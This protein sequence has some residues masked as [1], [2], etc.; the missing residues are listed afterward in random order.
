MKLSEQQ[1]AVVLDEF[2]RQVVAAPGNFDI[3]LDEEGLPHPYY[4][5]IVS[6][7]CFGIAAD[8]EANGTLP[9]ST[10]E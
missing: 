3:L 6:N 5:S 1:L 10:P 4:G 9:P 8:L 7:F 2:A